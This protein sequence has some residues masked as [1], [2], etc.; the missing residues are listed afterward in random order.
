MDATKPTIQPVPQTL[1]EAIVFYADPDNCLRLMVEI[2]WS[3]GVACP[4]CGDMA[5]R[6][7]KTRHI[8]KC[9][10]CKKQFSV[11]VGTIFEDSPGCVCKVVG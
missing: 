1:Q 7:L 5:V 8:F 6:F 3:N 4:A 10:G 11:K 2:R 9:K